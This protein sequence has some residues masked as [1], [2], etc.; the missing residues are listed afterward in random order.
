MV[1]CLSITN[2]SLFY[3]ILRMSGNFFLNVSNILAREARW[4]G[5]RAPDSESRGAGFDPPTRGAVL[6]L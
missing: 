2:T 4:S 1:E 3:G 6:C 5:G